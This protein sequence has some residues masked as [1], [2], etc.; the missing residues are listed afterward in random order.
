M[1]KAD[2]AARLGQLAHELTDR[3]F[4]YVLYFDLDVCTVCCCHA[5]DQEWLDVS[6]DTP[7]EDLRGT[8][9]RMKGGYE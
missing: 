1:T 6:L 7:P 8:L 4:S 9:E 2:T 5:F 3:E